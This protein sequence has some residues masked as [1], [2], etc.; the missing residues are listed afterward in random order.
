MQDDE[1]LLKEFE[2]RCDSSGDA[3]HTAVAMLIAASTVLAGAQGVPATIATLME[4]AAAIRAHDPTRIL[5][6]EGEA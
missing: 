2:A 6:P 4:L 1:A 3:I 5:R